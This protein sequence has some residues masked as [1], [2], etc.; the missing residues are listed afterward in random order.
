MN[1]I[2]AYYVMVA[3][4]HD[5]AARRPRYDSIVPK[6]SLAARITTALETLVQLGRSSTVQPV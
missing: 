2:A 3:S 6:R 5:R 1:P 4:D